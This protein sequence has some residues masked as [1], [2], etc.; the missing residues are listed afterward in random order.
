MN[1][2]YYFDLVASSLVKDLWIIAGQE[3]YKIIAKHLNM[4]YTSWRNRAKIKLKNK[5]S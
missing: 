2:K 5:Q 4:A 3:T 1:K